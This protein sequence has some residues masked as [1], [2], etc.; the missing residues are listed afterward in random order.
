MKK[1]LSIMLAAL[2]LLA[3]A[4]CVTGTEPVAEQP[5]EAP[6]KVT[7]KPVETT[8]EPVAPPEETGSFEGLALQLKN[9]TGVTI[10][11]VYI[12]PVGEDMGNSVVKAGW[13]D[14]D[15]DPEGYEQFIYIVREAGKEM[16][17]TV[18]FEDE[19]KAVWP[20]GALATYEEL[21]FKKG[22]DVAGWEHSVIDK[23]EDKAACD[24][25]AAIGK[26]A[27]NFY[28]GYVAVAAEIKNKTGKNITEF[29]L[30]EKDGDAAAYNNMIQYL[31][32]NK[33]VKLEKWAP[34]K[35][36]EGGKYV[37]SYFLR[38]EAVDYVIDVVYDDGATLSAP[39]ENWFTPDGDGHQRNEISM[40]DA[41]DPDIWE[42]KYDDGNDDDLN[43]PIDER[44]A[45]EINEVGVPA[46]VWYPVYPNGAA[47]VDADMLEAALQLL[48]QNAAPLL[49]AGEPA[50]EP[51]VGGDPS[52]WAPDNYQ[53]LV[54]NLKNK[55]GMTI[56]ELYIYEKG[57]DKGNSVVEAGWKDKD[58]DGDNYEKNI[59]I[60]RTI[61]AE[62]E[63]YVVFEDGTDMTCDLGMLAIY[64]KIS[65]KGPTAED[66]KH[67]ANDD[68]AD[69][70]AMNALLDAHIPSDGFNPHEQ[71]NT[72]P[73]GYTGLHLMLKNK[74]GKEI[75]K[76]YLFPTGEEKG[77]NIFKTVV[78]GN[79]PTEDKNVEGA[80]HEVFAY[81]FRETAKLG[82][83]TLIV[84]Y[85]DDTEETFELKPLEDYT[86]F[87]I[88]ETV[89]EFKQK[90]SEDA[91]DITKMN[92]VAAAGVSTDGEEFAPIA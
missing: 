89:E 49:E 72:V 66:V 65:L 76:V 86:V 79:I 3:T 12:Y 75:Y 22:T 60:I 92:E 82:A 43:M 14:K 13:Q 9:K 71:A 78:E 38:P 81:V 91:E 10:N 34:G 73:A 83:M 28:P 70:E 42:V 30:Y 5:T 19:T 2:M 50:G 36:K 27:D 24:L 64:D 59:Y 4:A 6:A 18:V 53:D 7:E 88:K 17:V 25:V 55:T 46:D 37:F 11:A 57:A 69:I 51:L 85:A 48:A 29:R 77:K 44:L 26:T 21:S 80:P 62:F 90:V 8:P 45:Y 16:E 39:I 47:A 63:M 41:A 61:G 68:P 15:V 23:D 1:L 67:E 32:T 20:V 74:S 84:R 87:T 54:L 56:N 31:Y 35:A 58:A 40:K 52:T 33:G